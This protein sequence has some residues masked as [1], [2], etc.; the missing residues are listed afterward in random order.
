M[1]FYKFKQLQFE[2]NTWK[3]ML[4]FMME[5]NVY[6]KNR[7]S[8]ILADAGTS[9][10]LVE[11]EDFQSRFLRS[12]E[13]IRILRND[14]AELEQFISDQKEDAV[15]EN[16]QIHSKLSC[17]RLNIPLVQRQEERMKAEFNNFLL[18]QS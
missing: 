14:V 16:P 2:C 17:I 10:R 3:R 18:A 13:L 1:T 7:L 12:D 11:I 6:L 4:S 9:E 15:S 5:E 8:E